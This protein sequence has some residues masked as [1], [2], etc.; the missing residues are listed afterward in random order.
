MGK[1]R[2][3]ATQEKVLVSKIIE[4]D[5]DLCLE[6]QLQEA[7]TA[8]ALESTAGG[9][10]ADETNYKVDRLGY[11]LSL[12]R[13]AQES[14]DRLLAQKL[15]ND[16]K[17][18]LDLLLSDKKLVH[19]MMQGGDKPS[20]KKGHEK[21]KTMP[22][23]SSSIH[24]TFRLYSKGLVSEGHLKDETRLFGGFGA[25]ICD[26]YD[27]PLVEMKK[28]LGDEL[29]ALPEA[30][31]LTAIIHV[32]GWSLD[33]DLRRVTLYCD[34]S[35]ILAYV[36]G[37]TQSEDST[38]AKLVEEVTSLQS[39]FLSFK[40]LPVRRDIISLVKLAKDAITSQTRWI[41]DGVEWE[42]CPICYDYSQPQEMYEVPT[43]FHRV[44]MVCMRKQVTGLLHN[45]KGTQ[46]PCCMTEIRI[47]DCKPIAD[48]AQVNLMIERKREDMINI[49][50]RVY[51]PNPSCS[52]LMSKRPLLMETRR[53][54]L[55]AAESGARKCM[56]CGF[57]FCIN[58]ATKWHYDLTCLQFRKTKAYKNSDRSDFEAAAERYGWKTCSVCQTTVE[59]AE[60]CKHMTC[61]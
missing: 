50:D 21:A 46:C 16:G 51:C 28:A 11:D 3:L 32:L 31:E 44:C 36:T 55:D 43:C 37:K 39:R 61:R 1:D 60:G 49:A 48:P 10:E 54:F 24:E 20:K 5:A 14:E 15:V 6:L 22:V 13:L 41:E 4:E 17:K 42:T 25:S 29:L 26:S 9:C 45:W 7:I 38:I 30:V 57:C 34:D 58:C 47:E 18:D 12:T 19:G 40:A 53:V 52:F 35:N 59:L 2:E 8:S 33:L 23:Y 56:E 27:H